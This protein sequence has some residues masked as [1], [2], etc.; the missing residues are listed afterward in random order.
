MRLAILALCVS[1]SGCAAKI[2][3]ATP[4]SVTIEAMDIA[5]ATPLAQAE[6]QKHARHARYAGQTE[7]D[8]LNGYVFDC[9]L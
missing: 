7:V 1:L 3:A 6:C 5:A 8:F 2:I 4:R 9:V